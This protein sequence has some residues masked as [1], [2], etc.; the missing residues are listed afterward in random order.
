MSIE[1][2]VLASIIGEG[3]PNN[4]DVQEAMLNLSEDCFQVLPYREIFS[5]INKMFK[6]NERFDVIQMIS[7]VPDSYYSEFK[8]IA[9]ESAH[10]F[11]NLLKHD[12]G[13]LLLI[14]KQRI[15]GRLINNM[16]HEFNNEKLPDVSCATAVNRCFEISK[17]SLG[18]STHVFTSEHLADKVLNGEDDLSPHVPTGIE[19][20][21]VLTHG[22]FKN[23]SL[24]TIAG[25]PSTGKSCFGVFIA[26][27]IASNHQKKHVLF[28]SLEM[29]A[30]D[31]YKMQLTSI[32]GKQYATFSEKELNN[33]I[34]KSLECPF[35]IDEQS[36][37]SIEYI[38]TFSRMTNI[39][40][41]VGVI[42]VDYL[43]I[44]QT[45]KKFENKAMAQTEIT[46]K[47]KALSKELDCIVIA[48]S[49]VNRDYA[50]R[51]DKC[52]VT[53]DAADSSGSERSSAYW[54]GIHRPAL[55]DDCDPTLKNQFVVKCRKHRWGDPW[56]AY[57]AF[58]SATFGEVNQHLFY[59]I[60]KPSNRQAKYKKTLNDQIGDMED[61]QFRA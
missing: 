57:F 17:L 10:T 23:R 49:Q 19:A 41:P 45:E 7:L 5:L 53:S 48:L 21:D 37:S 40:H 51:A 50:N 4:V 61:E 20:L 1:A 28:F 14:R 24:I 42:V 52:P 11:T 2:R 47:L 6:R 44:I 31:I 59:E 15:M 9:T 54:L 12:V 13:Q 29:D 18:E 58:N 38:E 56:T 60:K 25:K 33:A 8:E 22:G 34:A 36:M 39:K 35:T 26:Q 55:D 27:K 32:A 30:M 43:S 46:S 3:C 16:A